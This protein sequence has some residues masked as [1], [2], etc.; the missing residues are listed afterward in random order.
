MMEVDGLRSV[1]SFGP[2]GSFFPFCTAFSLGLGWG[3]IEFGG[4]SWLVCDTTTHS[5]CNLHVHA[6]LELSPKLTDQ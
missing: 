1:D 6:L 2:L 4:I 5:F 3:R